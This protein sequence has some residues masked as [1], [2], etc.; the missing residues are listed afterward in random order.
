M[1]VYNP[2]QVESIEAFYILKCPECTY[3]TKKDNSFYDHAIENHSKSFVF[4]GKPTVKIITPEEILDL[5][6]ES[7]E[8]EDSE[9]LSESEKTLKTIAEDSSN[10]QTESGESKICDPLVCKICFKTVSDLN[11]MK[12]H[13]KIHAKNVIGQTKILKRESSENLTTRDGGVCPEC[14]LFYKMLQQHIKG[15]HPLEKPFKCKQCKYAHAR[16]SGLKQHIVNSHPK[17]EDMKI[18]QDC[19]AM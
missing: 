15:Q 18:C 19:G 7:F 8:V 12:R 5:P 3:Y 11:N 16:K 2:W 13:M 17:E 14:G 6:V 4:F 9:T 1:D 10:G